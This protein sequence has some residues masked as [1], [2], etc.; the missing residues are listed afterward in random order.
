GNPLPSAKRKFCNPVGVDL[1]AQVEIGI[2]TQFILI[3]RVDDLATQTAFDADAVGVRGDVDGLGVGV[4]HG[5]LHPVA[6]VLR[7][8]EL[9]TVVSRGSDGAPRVESGELWVHETVGS[10]NSIDAVAGA[11]VR[12]APPL[13]DSL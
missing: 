9:E 3:P 11:G 6:H 5:E 7:E 13:V 4:V 1:M 12:Q 10:A 2:G 8:I